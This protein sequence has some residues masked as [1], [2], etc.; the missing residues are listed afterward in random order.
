M[1]S[2]MNVP[3]KMESANQAQI[4]TDSGRVLPILMPL[5]KTGIHFIFI[6]TTNWV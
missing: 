5:R 6:L 4:S 1:F 3:R 2:L